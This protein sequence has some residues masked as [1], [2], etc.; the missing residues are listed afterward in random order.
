MSKRIIFLKQI[1]MINSTT[2]KVEDIVE[3]AN[4]FK[5]IDLIIEN[6][7]R[8]ITETFIV[9]SHIKKRET[10]AMKDCQT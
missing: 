4:H 3:I 7:K 10:D 9:A 2:I 1:L 8:P 6:A 5:C